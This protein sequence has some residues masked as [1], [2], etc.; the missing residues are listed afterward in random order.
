MKGEHPFR[1]QSSDGDGRRRSFIIVACFLGDCVSRMDG[2]GWDFLYS[3]WDEF[4]QKKRDFD[5]A[6]EE[7]KK[8]REAERKAREEA[9]RKAK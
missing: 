9:Y 4:K 3:L 7:E 1:G 2:M 8:L 6:M 5:V